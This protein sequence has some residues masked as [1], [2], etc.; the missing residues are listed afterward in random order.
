MKIGLKNIHYLSVLVLS[1]L[2]PYLHADI[3]DQFNLSSLRDTTLRQQWQISK[4][5]IQEQPEAFFPLEIGPAKVLKFQM[6]DCGFRGNGFIVRATISEDN[7]KIATQI[8]NKPSPVE[9]SASHVNELKVWSIDGQELFG[10]KLPSDRVIW[11]LALSPDYT[12]LIVV[13]SDA[14]DE[15]GPVGGNSFIKIWDLKNDKLLTTILHPHP[16][17]IRSLQYSPDGTKFI[18]GSLDGTVKSWTLDGQLID[19]L[20]VGE[21]LRKVLYSPDYKKI[22]VDYFTT[23]ARV[24]SVDGTLLTS[25]D[26]VSSAVFTADSSKII[27]QGFPDQTLKMWN[28]NGTYQVLGTLDELGYYRF[29]R[30]ARNI[31]RVAS[32][33]ND[34]EVWDKH[35]HL[36]VKLRVPFW[37]HS[38]QDTCEPRCSSDGTK[39]LTTAKDNSVTIWDLSSI[40]QY[41]HG[42]LTIPQ[43]LLVKL[44]YEAKNENL[45]TRFELIAKREKKVKVEELQRIFDSFSPQLQKALAS[46]YNCGWLRSRL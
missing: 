37:W 30:Y 27:T 17:L 35:G 31:V 29:N 16:D 40:D 23:P 36:L 4:H 13:L 43:A 32:K 46:K 7:T 11:Q 21:G 2:M 42:E 15:H 12:K 3:F 24:W 1:I 18:T 45:P 33:K 9:T 5:I 28:E 19:T 34:T 41:I 10:F 20:N 6:R 8:C 14:A 44:L 22:I 26:R 38:W 25:L 39:I